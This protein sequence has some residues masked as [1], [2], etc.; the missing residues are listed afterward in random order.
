VE[1][2]QRVEDGS[3]GSEDDGINEGTEKTGHGHD[4][5]DE[6]ARTGVDT[7]THTH[8]HSRF[9][10][11]YMTTTQRGN[12]NEMDAVSERNNAVKARKMEQGAKGTRKWG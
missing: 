5:E 3:E 1:R 4:D 8:T 10:W 6:P 12:Q 11:I 9:T 7:A 2:V